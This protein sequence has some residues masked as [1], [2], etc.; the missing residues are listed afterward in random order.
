M[1]LANFKSYVYKKLSE[2]RKQRGRSLINILNNIG[3]RCEP[4]GAPEAIL[5]SEDWNPFTTT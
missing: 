1:V 3:A 5:W 4:C 2:E